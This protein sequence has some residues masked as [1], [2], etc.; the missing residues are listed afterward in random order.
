MMTSRL[1][2]MGGV[3]RALVF[4]F[5]GLI[6]DT[7]QPIY[8][9]WAEVYARH[10]EEL[11]FDFWQTIVGRG[12]NYFDPLADLE[13]RIGRSLDRE[14][15]Q[16]ERQRRQ[17]EMVAEQTVLPGVR[18]WWDEARAAGVGL[19]VASGSLRSWVVGHLERLG[20]DGC[21]CIRGRDDVA[22]PKPAPDVYLAV[23]ACLG[24]APED[25]I[26][27]EDSTFGVEAAKRAG[28]FCVA[29]PSSMTRGHDLSRADLLVGSLDEVTFAEVAARR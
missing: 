7:E 2:R 8:R 10:G 26:A 17:R 4:D 5:D 3:A 9:A 21:P 6:L 29:V 15:I 16:A 1:G 27:V 20:L 13:A 25:A 12:S 14:L 24:V 22:R 23:L 11:G 19:G 18:E 28:L